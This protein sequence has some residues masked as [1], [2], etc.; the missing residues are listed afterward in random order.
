MHDTLLAVLIVMVILL[1]MVFLPLGVSAAGENGGAAE[2]APFVDVD[3]NAW[4]YE[5][6]MYVYEHGILYGTGNNCFSP[7]M[8]ANAST[9]ICALGRI[10]GLDPEYNPK[11]HLI[12]RQI[13]A[14]CFYWYLTEQ[15][16]YELPES[17]DK[18]EDDHEI[19]G[20]AKQSVYALREAGIIYGY[21][22]GTFRPDRYV[23]RAELAS[24][25]HE[26]CLWM[27]AAS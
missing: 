15:K 12:P 20:F 23:T 7:N 3:P 16:G 4:Y 19:A 22:D 21:D 18:F 13:I 25:L 11:S 9:V 24:M 1:I 8:R 5:D 17:K 10:D 2:S 6:V 26:M 27:D 14:V